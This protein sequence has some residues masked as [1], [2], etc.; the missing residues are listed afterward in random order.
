VLCG[1]RGSLDDF[2]GAGRAAVERS[3]VRMVPP[4]PGQGPERAVA[5][6]LGDAP[7]YV[8]LDP[9]VLDPADNPVPYARR[10]GLTLAQLESLLRAVR[11]RGPVL[12]VELTAFHTDEDEARRQA[13]GARLAGCLAELAGE[14]R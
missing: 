9:D 3:A 6:L 8:H 5:A 7:V 1:V 10:G 12:G 14:G 4:A 11:C 2:D 13:L